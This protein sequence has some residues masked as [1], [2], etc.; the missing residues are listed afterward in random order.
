[1]NKFI[2]VSLSVLLLTG[3]TACSK[4]SS[5]DF[6]PIATYGCDVLNV[7]NTGEYIGEN[8][9][10]LFEEKYNVKVNYSMFE[11]NEM[12]YTK[13]MDNSQYDVLVPSDYMIERLIEEKLLQP[14]DMAAITNFK[15]ITPSI[16]NKDY[17]PGNVYSVPYFYGNVG[18]IYNSK[19]IDANDVETLGYNVFLE[20]KYKGQAYMYDSERDSFMIA[21]KA[22]GY[23]MNTDVEEE[24][25]AAYEWLLQVDKNIEPAYVTDEVIDSVINEEKDLAIVYSGDAA[26][27]TSENED[28]EFFLPTEGT[29]L[30]FDAMVIP[31]NAGCPKLANEFINFMLSYDVA[32][33]NSSYVGYTSSVQA[34]ADYLISS[35]GDYFENNA[36]EVRTDYEKDEVFKN[37]EIMKKKLSDLWIKVKSQ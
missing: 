13:L 19:N 35:E 27:M 21:F 5:N 17:D 10:D 9:L 25:Q 3:A 8:T 20:E 26:Y 18:I 37:N 33:D 4:G 31:A 16:T 7:Y 2:K 12:M 24:I 11:S 30:W 22:L 29:N 23:S 32:L 1:M 6:D 28:L 36:Y 34:V 15:D 14:I